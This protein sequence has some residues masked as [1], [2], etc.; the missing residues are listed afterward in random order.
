VMGKKIATGANAVVLDVKVGQG[1]FMKDLDAARELARTMVALGRA[2]ELP[3]V[4]V[5]SG[6]SEPLGRAVGNALEVREAIE[7]L[8]GSGP[9]DLVS[10]CLTLGAEVLVAA[11]AAPTDREARERLSRTLEDGSAL[12]AF[13]SLVEGMGGDVR[14]I[15]E[16]DRLPR[17]PHMI[18][19]PAPRDGYA[20]GI[21]ALACGQAAM[22]LGAGRATK[23]DAIDPAVGV[24]LRVKTGV[25]VVQGQPL[26]TV[27]SREPE[28]VDSVRQLSSAF[29]WS[30]TPV[31]PPALV[32]D[33]IR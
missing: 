7:T 16:P 1:A 17:A 11:G 3:T 22:R 9:A 6:M 27:H 23:G 20:A 2:V 14:C 12:A 25:R 32:L 5:L 28:P 31:S 8:N 4:A 18:D 24:V 10:L 33:I 13:R 30:D 19:V 21:D 15:D 29:R 26:A